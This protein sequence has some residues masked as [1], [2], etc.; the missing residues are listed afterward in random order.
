MDGLSLG[1][2]PRVYGNTNE[3][4]AYIP[5]ETRDET[6]AQNEWGSTEGFFITY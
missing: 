5:D 2:N 4:V 6:E 1:L 3:I